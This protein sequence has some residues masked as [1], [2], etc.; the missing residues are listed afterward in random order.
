MLNPSANRMGTESAFAV[1]AR[2]GVLSAQ[3]H[4][5]INLGIGQPDFKTPEHIVEAGMR[6]LQDG[7]HGYTPSMGLMSLRETVAEDAQQR[8]GVRP[9]VSHIQIVPGGKPVMF[10][11]M[12]LLGWPG[13]EILTPDPGF[14]IYQ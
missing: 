6:A 2:A 1:L 11:A 13:H 3:G 14:P 10:T 8:Y 9:D 12:M 5:I 7:A 4:D